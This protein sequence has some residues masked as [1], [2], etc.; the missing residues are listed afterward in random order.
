VS[1]GCN[2]VDNW[3]PPP[4]LNNRRPSRHSTI[5][6]GPIIISEVTGRFHSTGCRTLPCVRRTESRPQ[7]R[8]IKFS[9]L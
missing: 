9:I 5:R 3:L 8:K 6:G 7:K 1:A 2:G 4:R